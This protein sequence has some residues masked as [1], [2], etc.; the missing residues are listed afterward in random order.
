MSSSR[1]AAED[2][3]DAHP[4]DDIFVVGKVGFAILASIDLITV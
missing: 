4:T 2:Y 3:G 1:E